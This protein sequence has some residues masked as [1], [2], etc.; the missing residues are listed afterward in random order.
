MERATSSI[1]FATEEF[2]KNFNIA[3]ENILQIVAS[4]QTF[5]EE[6]A[7]KNKFSNLRVP[8]LFS[9]GVDSLMV[10]LTVGDVLFRLSREVD[11]RRFVGRVYL[12]TVAFGEKQEVK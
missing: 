8:V 9:G 3:V 4:T 10:A 5:D 6:N 7:P 11:R 12:I 1:E 2:T